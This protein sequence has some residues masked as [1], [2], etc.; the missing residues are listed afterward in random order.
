[1]RWGRRKLAQMFALAALVALGAAAL[2]VMP[3]MA[4]MLSRPVRRRLTDDFLETLRVAYAVTL[5]LAVPAVLILSNVLLKAR[6]RGVRRPVLARLLLLSVSCML[7]VALLEGGAALWLAWAH[8]LPKLPDQ[9]AAVPQRSPG[10]E[11]RR[12]SLSFDT[13]TLPDRF[14]ES[15]ASS[16]SLVVI[17]ES[18]AQGFPYYPWLSVGQIVAWKLE[19]AIPERRFDVNILA[20]G[21]DDLEMMHHKLARLERR[22]DAMIIY[23]GHNEFQARYPWS[24]TLKPPERPEPSSVFDRCSEYSSLYKMIGEAISLNRLDEPPPATA[25]P[26]LD[27]PMCSAAEYSAILTDFQR[28][29]EAIVEYCGRLGTL[30]ILVIPPANESGFEPSRTVLPGRLSTEERSALTREFQAARSAERDP[31]SSA[32][33]YRAL[34]ARQP[35]FAEAH[36][37]LA[38]LLERSG[39]WNEARQH[40][41]LARDYDGLPI[42]FP[43]VF[44]DVYR[45]VAARHDCILIDGP[46]VLRAASAHGILDDTLFHDAHHPTLRGH[47]LL[48]EAI[49]RA[50]RVRH[51]FGWSGGLEPVVSPAECAAHFGM[52]AMRWWVVCERSSEFYRHIAVTRYDPF[53]RL[54]KSQRLGMAAQQIAGGTPPEA[55]GYPGV[56]CPPD[57]T[58]VR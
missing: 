12:A 17:G 46:D 6:R 28:R 58:P 38:R 24:R 3:D 26:L 57:T 34:V 8:R 50:L 48:A 22:P 5:A 15:P 33:I 37:R 53:E 44:Q 36:F 7:G 32:A 49:L 2:L 39:D 42:R 4:L 25:R 11:P 20:Q 30:P 13:P 45:G 55:T 10:Q 31:T 52:D 35:A 14:A 56:G 23:C 18:S 9:F 54:A 29:L 40:Y 16:V 21:G 19:G 27:W 51:A 41:I 47:A 43:N 1:M